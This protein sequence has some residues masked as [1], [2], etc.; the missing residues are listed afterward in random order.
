MKRVSIQ[1][2]HFKWLSLPALIHFVSERARTT[3]WRTSPSCFFRLR[4]ECADPLLA[5]RAA[6]ARQH[7]LQLAERSLSPCDRQPCSEE[8]AVL[9]GHL[10]THFDPYI[11]V[12]GFRQSLRDFAPAATAHSVAHSPRYGDRMEASVAKPLPRFSLTSSS[13]VLGHQ[14]L[15]IGV[16]ATR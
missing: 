13:V 7:E 8:S 4:R 11:V 2:N 3:L 14:S 9:V 10:G 6:Q 12:D 15:Q 16:S 1:F 5:Q